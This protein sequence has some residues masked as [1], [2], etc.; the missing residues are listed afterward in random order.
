MAGRS[1]RSFYFVLPW[2]FQTPGGVNQVVNNLIREF[3]TREHLGLA[4]LRM[5]LGWEP[6]APTSVAGGDRVL[7]V[8]LHS[9]H[10]PERP[11]RSLFTYLLYLPKEL[12]RLKRIARVQNVAVFNLHFPD[13]Q[14]L[15]F[16]LLRT[17]GLYRGKVFLSMHGSDI[18]SAHRTTGAPRAAWRWLLRNATEVVACSDGL[19]EEILML[20]PR[21][22]TVTI[23]NGIDVDLFASHAD[24]AFSWPLDL[25]DRRIIVN[26]GSFEYRKGHDVLVRAFAKIASIYEDATLLLAGKPGPQSLPIRSLIRDLDLTNRVHIFEDVPHFQIYDLLTHAT[27]FVLATR[28]IKGEMGEGFAIAILEAAAAKAPVIATA[29]CGVEE[30]IVNGKTGLIA[31]LDDPDSLARAIREALDDPAKARDRAERLHSLVREKFT[32]ERAATVYAELA[33][34]A[35]R[36]R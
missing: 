17:F 22:R 2:S 20:E 18:R 25:K 31:T 24:P 1:E 35:P 9:P 26:V 27:V 28:W 11:L 29:S 16:V 34:E 13:L 5:E 33:C 8:R 30:I 7:G 3:A 36:T 21:C 10:D 32:W 12:L 14:A 4:P 23:Y 19:R 15:T 6:S